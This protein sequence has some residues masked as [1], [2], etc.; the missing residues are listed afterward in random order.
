M[1]KKKEKLLAIVIPAYKSEY[2]EQTLD[3]I[4]HQTS[5]DFS[6]YIGDDCS[7]YDLQSIVS[8]YETDLNIIYHRFDDNLGGRDL[9][10]HWNRCVDL[11]ESAEWIWLFSDDDIM[12]P[13]CVECFLRNAE[14]FREA[15][16]VHFDIKIMDKSNNIIKKCP[17]YPQWLTN[18]TFFAELYRGHISARMPEFVFKRE[19]L[20]KNKGFENY[21]LAWRADNA[22][23]IKLSNGSGI[24]TVAGKSSCVLWRLSDNNIS[25]KYDSNII[26][27][28]NEST[29][30]FFNWVLDYFNQN[31]IK[32]NINKVRMIRILSFNLLVNNRKHAFEEI[33]KETL[34]YSYVD[35]CIKKMLVLL[36]VA[37]RIYIKKKI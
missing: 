15:N 36:I 5:H 3:S 7:P 14:S 18:A 21:P 30:S 34:R 33:Y 26:K 37:Y 17:P 28:K 20:L 4:Y 9:V 10:A 6:L 31:H 24:Y 19:A 27:I 29:I 8:K 25:G 32:L 1:K 35:S 13:R 11:V 12:E 22:S 23:V 2:L 16:V